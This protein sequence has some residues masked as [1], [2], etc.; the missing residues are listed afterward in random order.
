MRLVV[1][2]VD[3]DLRTDLRLGAAR[4]RD[5]DLDRCAEILDQEVRPRRLP[6]VTGGV[7]LRLHIAVEQPERERGQVLQVVL[8]IEG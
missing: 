6:R 3:D 5:L 4:V 2:L 1:P 7:L 8:V